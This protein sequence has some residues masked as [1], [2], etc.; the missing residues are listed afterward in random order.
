MA[1]SARELL[2]AIQEELAPM[3]RENRLVPLIER[4]E[5]PVSVFATIAG[6]E[7][8]IV[9][10]DLRSMHFLAARAGERNAIEF[11]AGLA[12]GEAIAQTKLAGLAAAGGMDEDELRGYEPMAG[13]Q[14]YPA[15]FAWLALNGE[16]ADVILGVVANFAAWGDYCGRIAKAMRER[17]GLADEACAFFDFFAE[18]IPDAVEQAITAAQ[19]GMDAG[20]H[21]ERA[22]HRYGR[23]FQSYELSF[24]NTI[25]DEL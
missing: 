22:A 3:E 21:D 11:F 4:G 2:A 23:L 9:R 6:E 20:H 17:Y 19:A 15:Y 14:A 16:I 18:P 8:H 10:S 25:V 5:A 7:S 13:C 1:G 12:Q 24:W